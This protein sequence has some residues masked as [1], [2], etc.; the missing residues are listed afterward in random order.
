MIGNKE[1]NSE[2]KK[3]KKYIAIINEVEISVEEPNQDG[4]SL[5]KEA[6]V[7]NTECVDL[8][9]LLAHGDFERISLDEEVDL[10]VSGVEKFITKEAEF[11]NY[12]VNGQ[13]ETTDQKK[14]TPDKI[15]KLAGIDPDHN[16]LILI[17]NDGTKVSYAR[18]GDKE[19]MIT[20]PPMRFISEKKD[21][22]CDLEQCCH[23]GVIPVIS[24][25]YIIKI[26]SE[27][28]TVEEKEMTGRQILALINQTPESY[29]LRFKHKNGS[30]SV[31]ADEV[32]DFTVCGVER[33]SAKAKNCTEGRVNLRDF[34]LPE[35][36][37]SFLKELD[38][39][40]DSFSEGSRWLILR[41]YS[42]PS[43]YNVAKCDVAIA[44]PANYP[45]EQLDMFYMYPNL[46]R[47]DHKAIGA[48]SHQSIEG[49]Q[50]QRWSRHRTTLNRWIPGEDNLA[51]HLE[52]MNYS[53]QEE[54]AKR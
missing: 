28:Y 39:T 35:E 20:C 11:R 22:I 7:K 54:F 38:L 23:A 25:R 45:V 52:L 14:L 2:A 53:L 27:K 19:I 31:G 47:T 26:N 15:L 43:G 49:K 32:V 10:S 8:Y 46:V 13:P 1:N 21:S 16:F 6:D 44:I 36:D 42:L 34:S 24:Y 50:Y 3:P 48:L 40:W 5:L 30:T 33:F 51:T 37:A 18:K 12:S 17:K 9:Q 41:D 29:Y 4:R